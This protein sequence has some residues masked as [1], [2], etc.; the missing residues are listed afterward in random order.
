MK[1]VTILGVISMLML[2]LVST[3]FASI[4]KNLKYGQRDLEVTELQEFLIDKGL[5]KTTPSNFFGL[6]TLKAVK[7]YQ[8]SVGVSSTGFV[9]AL[10]RKKLTKK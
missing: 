6:L 8:T 1:K 7:A 3:S 10:T 9:G 2:G 5:L 4:D